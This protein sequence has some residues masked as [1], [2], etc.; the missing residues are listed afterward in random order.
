MHFNRIFQIV[1]NNRKKVLYI[2][3]LL[4][5]AYLNFEL[6]RVF[7]KQAGH[8]GPR[9]LTSQSSFP[10]ILPQFWGLLAKAVLT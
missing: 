4:S 2:Q 1:A 10:P 8:G 3:N 7:S 9:S 6:V 5:Y